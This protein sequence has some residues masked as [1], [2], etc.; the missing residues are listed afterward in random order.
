LLFEKEK[1][2]KGNFKTKEKE[3]TPSAA[4]PMVV[5]GPS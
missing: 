1:K 5:F 2:R 4:Q 3:K